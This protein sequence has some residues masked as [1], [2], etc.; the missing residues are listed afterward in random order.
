VVVR[1]KQKALAEDG[2]VSVTPIMFRY[3]RMCLGSGRQRVA[4]TPWKVCGLP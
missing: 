3:S 1:K 4:A 2:G